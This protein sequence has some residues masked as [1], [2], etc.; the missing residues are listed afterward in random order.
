MAAG[1][2][3]I[4]FGQWLE[5]E[6]PGLLTTA[7][8]PVVDAVAAVLAAPTAPEAMPTVG[9]AV[10]RGAAA[11]VESG[12]GGATRA[13]EGSFTATADFTAGTLAGTLDLAAGG[14]PWGRVELA[15]PDLDGSRFTAGATS[16]LGHAGSADGAFGGPTAGT[17]GGRFTLDGPSS[18]QGVFAG[19]AE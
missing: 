9:S 8:R 14:T 15:A 11:A 4:S 13:L 18:V 16:S 17:L 6:A 7:A 10:Y 12:A 19:A 1:F 5:A 2:D 3:H